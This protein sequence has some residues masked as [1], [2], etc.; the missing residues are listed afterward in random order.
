MRKSL[1]KKVVDVTVVLAAATCG[2]L[3]HAHAPEG[4]PTPAPPL[5]P[6]TPHP[7]PPAPTQN[8]CRPT[9]DL[10]AAF[11]KLYPLEGPCLQDP[12][13]R[14]GALREE[15]KTYVLPIVAQF[16][17]VECEARAHQLRYEY[18]EYLLS[19]LDLPEVLLGD[20]FHGWV[21]GED[22]LQLQDLQKHQVEDPE[23][24]VLEVE[25]FG[26]EDPDPEDPDPEDLDPGDL[27]P[28]DLDPEDPDPENLDP[29]NLDAEDPNPEDPDPEYLEL[30]YI[31]QEYLEVE[32]IDPE[33][34][35]PEYIDPE[36][37][38]P[39]YIDPEYIELEEL[40]TGVVSNTGPQKVGLQE[41]GATRPWPSAS[42]LLP[43]V[44]AQTASY[45]QGLLSDVHTK[46]YNIYITV[47][48]IHCSVFTT[49]GISLQNWTTTAKQQQAGPHISP[50]EFMQQTQ[51]I[52]MSMLLGIA[53]I[54]V[55]AITVRFYLPRLWGNMPPLAPV[56]K[57]A[58]GAGFA[59][60][61]RRL[62]Q[63]SA[64]GRCYYD[65]RGPDCTVFLADD[66]LLRPVRFT[67]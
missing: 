32:Y 8:T 18:L 55:V 21:R 23:V 42:V 67:A 28:E 29:E 39:E 34:I 25:Y 4:G 20:T 19:G 1:K 5:R 40:Q 36:Y 54:A 37:I 2:Y 13:P 48:D 49:M 14:E 15:L 16:A 47:Y 56:I 3:Y 57:R 43:R 59:R 35:D 63:P 60:R 6:A 64:P 41:P 11:D 30:E 45:T 53:A 61:S 26:L 58:M 22:D 66:P 33:Y 12:C 44:V 52:L 46:V 9:V 24:Q 10:E 17:V 50:T 62:P 38:D 65:D 27:D 7:F 31:D 51:L